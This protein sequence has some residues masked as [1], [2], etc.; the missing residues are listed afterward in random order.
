MPSNRVAPS[1]CAEPVPRS[2][3]VSEDVG[4]AVRP[5]GSGERLSA[6]PLM[7]PLMPVRWVQSAK[8]QAFGCACEHVMTRYHRAHALS[9]QPPV[10]DRASLGRDGSG[11]LSGFASVW[12]GLTNGWTSD[13]KTTA[14]SRNAGRREQLRLRPLL[15]AWWVHGRPARAPTISF[16]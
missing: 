3:L 12:D 14:C 10:L 6:P 13:K 8:E 5:C 7:P 4:C 11:Q 16:R 1:P 15:Q 9:Q 2:G